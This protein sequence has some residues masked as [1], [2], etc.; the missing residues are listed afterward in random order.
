M[1]QLN[2]NALSISSQVYN[3]MLP[4]IMT[5]FDMTFEAIIKTSN[6]KRVLKKELEKL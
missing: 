5:Q 3:L 1:H 2:V 4:I 6:I